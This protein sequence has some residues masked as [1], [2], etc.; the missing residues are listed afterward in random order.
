MG[1]LILNI[2]IQYGAIGFICAAFVDLSIRLTRSSEPFTLMEILGTIIAWPLV[3]GAFLTSVF[4][5]FFN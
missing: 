2:L 5:D 1:T 4:E 3:V